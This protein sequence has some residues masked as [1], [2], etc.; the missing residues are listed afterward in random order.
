VPISSPIINK[1]ASKMPVL[2]CQQGFPVRAF[3]LV[4][5]LILTK[6]KKHVLSIYLVYTKY[7]L[8]TYSRKW[9]STGCSVARARMT[10][11]RLSPPQVEIFWLVHYQ[12]LDAQLHYYVDTCL[13]LRAHHMV[14]FVEIGNVMKLT[15]SI[16]GHDVTVA[17]P[18][19]DHHICCS[20]FDDLRPVIHTGTLRT[21]TR[22]ICTVYCCTVMY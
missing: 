10:M 11:M 4:L 5:I 13:L 6:P 7:I 1:W 16:G 8:T 14:V 21:T 17:I 19:A 9:A 18:R 15:C 3:L 2:H 12:G 22:S 20:Y